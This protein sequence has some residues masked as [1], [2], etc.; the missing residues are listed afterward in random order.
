ML[1]PLFETIVIWMV[2]RTDV[3]G[4]GFEDFVLQ[5]GRTK[6]L[7]QLFN[8]YKCSFDKAQ[9][10]IRAGKVP[11]TSADFR[12]SLLSFYLYLLFD[13]KRWNRYAVFYNS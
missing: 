2:A 7:G 4:G 6:L 13:V 9:R 10:E 3:G 8:K 11:N 1:M 12:Y 5:R